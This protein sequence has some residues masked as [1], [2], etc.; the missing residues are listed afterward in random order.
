MVVIYCTVLTFD[1]DMYSFCAW[2][3]EAVVARTD[4]DACV[5][6][7]HRC[8]LK[9][10]SEKTMIQHFLSLKKPTGNELFVTATV[11]LI[12]KT[13]MKILYLKTKHRI[14]KSSITI[15]ILESTYCTYNIIMSVH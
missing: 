4:V 1:S 14:A 3:P 6:T 9:P 11:T 2:L 13:K 12:I 8:I 15:F 10:M 7:R 5:S